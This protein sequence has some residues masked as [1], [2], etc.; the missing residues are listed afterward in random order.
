MT[1]PWESVDWYSTWALTPSS[2]R[3]AISSADTTTITAAPI[4]TAR[5]E[6]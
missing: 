2:D 1:A 6:P 3:A 5:R 4:L